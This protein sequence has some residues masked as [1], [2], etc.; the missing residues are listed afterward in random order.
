M[1][2][3]GSFNTSAV[4]NFYFT[5]EWYRTGYN[6]SANEHYIHWTLYAHNTPGSYRTVYLKNLWVHGSQRLSESTG[7][8]YYDG[9]VVASGDTTVG[10]YNNEGDGS[11]GVSF[12]AGV[13]ISSGSNCSGSGSWNLDRIPR[14]ANL[15]SL[16]VQSRTHNSITLKYTTDRS[17]KLYVHLNNG[18]NWL[19]GGAP[20]VSNTTS[21]TITIRYKDRASTKKLD[22]NTTY[23][24]TVLCR[25]NSVD[26]DTSKNISA[27][28]YDIAKISS[29]PDFEHGND[30]NT[31]ITNPASISNLV[32][33]MKIGDVEILNRTATKGDNLI[34]FSNTELDKLYKQYEGS[35]NLTATFV[36]TGDGYTHSKNCI[37][38]LKG[39]QKT[40]KVNKDSDWKRGKIWTN[41]EGMWKRAIIWTNVNGIWKKSI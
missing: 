23:N 18:E 20:F 37:V 32:L 38:T 6:S 36:V 11:F 31:N 7:R 39:N 9:T 3:S 28:T 5:F 29:L 13:G 40:V 4:G 35:S 19:N 8:Q 1:A 2:T 34:Q 21:G 41:I 14:Y 16:S 30:I 15:T 25:N 33:A 24:I 26:L 17:A 12:E 22:P 10:S 27:T